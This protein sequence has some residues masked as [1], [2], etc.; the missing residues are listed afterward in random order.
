MTGIPERT[1]IAYRDNRFEGE[2]NPG[3]VDDTLDP[4]D[5]YIPEEREYVDPWTFRL[6]RCGHRLRALPSTTSMW[7][8]KCEC[9]VPLEEE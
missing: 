6:A 9:S 4:G 8:R 7:C 5:P 1:R 2:P 3:G